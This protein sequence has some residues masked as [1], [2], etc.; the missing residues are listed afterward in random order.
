VI[1]E[2]TIDEQGDVANARALDGPEELREAALEA[3]RRW[4]FVP[5]SLG[6]TPVKVIGTITYN[7]TL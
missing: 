3:A 7:F 1:V 6:G 2:V 5:T 4:K